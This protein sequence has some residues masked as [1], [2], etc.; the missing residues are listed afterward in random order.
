MI[1]PCT[2]C[3]Q[4]LPSSLKNQP[5]PAFCC[6]GC[7]TVYM[8]L[9]QQGL[10]QYYELKKKLP[11]FAT[12]TPQTSREIS[13]LYL[14]AL[15][16]KPRIVFYLEGIHCVACLWL[17]EKIPQILPG[18][19]SAQLTLGNNTATFY[20]SS[21]VK[22]SQ[23]AALLLDLGYRPHWIE[24]SEQASKLQTKED[25]KLL[26]QL[27]L[28]GGIAGNIMIFS[29][30]LYTGASGHLADYFRW[31]CFMMNIPI[32]L[33]CALPFYKNTLG[34][35]KLKQLSM[36]V[37]VSI[38]IILGTLVSTW[39]LIQ[40][41]SH[42]YFDSI[43]MLVF[44]LLSTRYLLRRITHFAIDSSQLVRYLLPQYAKKIS[45]DSEHSEEV[46][47]HSL[48]PGD[49][50]RVE[51]GHP[52]PVD[53]R[54]VSGKSWVNL[55]A[56]TGESYPQPVQEE[57]IVYS[58]TLNGEGFL[59]VAVLNTGTQTRLGKLL[60]EIE[61]RPKPKL[62]MLADL[63]AKHLLVGVGILSIALILTLTV[64]GR[65]EEGLNRALALWVVTC[66]CALA[67][68]TPL[69][70][71]IAL[72]KA[73][74]KGILIK[75]ADCLEACTRIDTLI[76]D[77]TGTLTYGNLEVLSWSIEPIFQGQEEKIK[78]IVWALEANSLHPSALAIRRHLA[79]YQND[80]VLH[81]QEEIT[82]WGVRGVYE[83]KLFEVCK[84]ACGIDI[85]REGV[86]IGTLTLGDQL[87]PDAKEILQALNKHYR[88]AL[89]SGDHISSVH[90]VASQLPITPSL[91]F[92][93][94][95]PEDKLNL[96]R[97][98]PHALM[99]GDGANDAAALSESK[100]GIAVQG[101]LEVSL[102][103]ADVYMLAPGI[104][105]IHNFLK[106]GH[107]TLILIKIN[108]AISMLYN[109][110]FSSLAVVGMITPLAAAIFMP[111][112]SFLVLLVSLFGFRETK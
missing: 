61:S 2:H 95:S 76:F 41:H 19:L 30:S 50:I 67:I 89:A 8:F 3:G 60:D 42:I 87:R 102:R 53:G 16:Y 37:P 93:N 32:V 103:A 25:R 68:A 31:I 18:V 27:G 78:A 111:A 107:S 9:T 13:F 92:A 26:V 4:P 101:S 17:I 81:D 29:V 48:F 71:S 38:S 112:S 5:E 73:A 57:S 109:L 99:V 14:D 54:V 21:T 12:Y 15:P 72:K 47:T 84:G 20:L 56:L 23:L 36:D 35:F 11:S 51:P 28:A 83:G 34:A 46:L 10:E 69:S 55:S 86:R 80:L 110:L 52:I 43:A 66:P 24:T 70:F 64:Q 6:S 75:N 62:V 94:Y 100:I 77:K 91:V 65:L 39:N 82:G 49:I 98:Y 104:A 44:L 33:Y 74:Q 108:L 7:E 106:I 85:K 59:D 58:G 45:A 22:P 40:G 1:S 63:L 96:I 97:D 79:A 88:L 105:P 90:E